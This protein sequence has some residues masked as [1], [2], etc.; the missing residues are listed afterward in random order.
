[1]GKTPER[2]NISFWG[3]GNIPWISISDMKSGK[4]LLSTKEKI[5]EKAFKEKFDSVYSVAGTLI[6]SFKLTVGKTSILGID[7]VH[8]E[9]II[10][11]FPYLSYDNIIRDYLL[12]TLEGLVQFVDKRDA[13]KGI[14]L[15][16]KKLDKMLI[17]LPPIE[18]ERRLLDFWTKTENEI[19]NL[20]QN[21][22]DY[23]SLTDSLKKA[24]LQSA[25]QGTL[26]EQCEDDEPA[27]VL[28]ERIRE[29]KRKQLGKKYVESSIYKGSDNRYY[30]K[31][32]TKEPTL[33]ENLP[34][35]IPSS[36]S[37]AR[38]NDIITLLSGRDLEPT[39]YNSNNQGVPYITGASNFINE[40]LIINRWTEK[41][42]V[43]PKKND[44]LITCKGTIGE[45]AYNP[46]EKI[47]I[48]RQVMAI[49]SDY[50]S[51]KYVEMFLKAYITEL[52]T[53]ARSFIP[54]ISRNDILELLM[55]IPPY[56]EQIRICTRIKQIFDCIKDEV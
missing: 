31:I 25:I 35:E 32:G 20:E 4:V 33:L 12:K 11:I 39:Q 47:H 43:I 15:N 29:E 21:Q 41:P 44:L 7:A 49:H 10:S 55:P 48:V 5:T 2:D 23:I 38:A 18:E 46:Y 51:L 30:E 26:V 54:G 56:N 53:K 14:T 42:I 52:Q 22:T 50:L 9:A 28:L 24:I 36:W 1:M 13:I 34:F 45:T 16:S 27:T 3:K 17:P 6:M 19:I 40:K 8:N 37:W